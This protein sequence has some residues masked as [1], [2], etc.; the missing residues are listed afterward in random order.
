M[1]DSN[2]FVVGATV[3]TLSV[4]VVTMFP[5]TAGVLAGASVL[6]VPLVGAD[7]PGALV[8]GSLWCDTTTVAS[9]PTVE[10]DTTVFGLL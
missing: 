7:V 8:E 5:G 9:L 1:G 4:W 10:A 2:A 6:V 3:G